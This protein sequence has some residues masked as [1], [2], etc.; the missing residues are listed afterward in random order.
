MGLPH[1]AD[2]GRGVGDEIV[3]AFGEVG[4]LPVKFVDGH[5]C[6]G[7]LLQETLAQQSKRFQ[8]KYAPGLDPG[9]VPVRIAIKF[10]QIAQTY[11]R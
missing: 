4:R 3:A 5:E 1:L 10:T 11:L 2:D 9:M 7:L 6:N 8:A